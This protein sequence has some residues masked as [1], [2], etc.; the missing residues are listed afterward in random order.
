MML[1]RSFQFTDNAT[2]SQ[3]LIKTNACIRAW[4]ISEGRVTV[5]VKEKE[6]AEKWDKIAKRLKGT[7]IGEWEEDDKKG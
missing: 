2:V 3:F 1:R 4:G 7:A 5:W 6:V